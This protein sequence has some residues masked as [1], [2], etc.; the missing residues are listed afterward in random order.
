[1][2]VEKYNAIL[3]T[4]VVYIKATG[5]LQNTHDH[6]KRNRQGEDMEEKAN[7]TTEKKKDNCATVNKQMKNIEKKMCVF[8]V[9]RRRRE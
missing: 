7:Q 3:L 2:D 4:E 1:M 6:K 5:S 8:I 9:K